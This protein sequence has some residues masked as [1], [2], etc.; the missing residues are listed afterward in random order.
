MYDILSAAS[1][2]LLAVAISHYP[3]AGPLFGSKSIV[4]SI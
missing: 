4:S 2:P 1:L 3:A